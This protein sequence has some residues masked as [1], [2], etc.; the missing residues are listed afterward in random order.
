MNARGATGLNGFW[1]YPTTATEPWRMAER[2][3]IHNGIDA[4]MNGASGAQLKS[5]YQKGQFLDKFSFLVKLRLNPRAQIYA[6]S[7]GPGTP[8]R[9][10]LDKFRLYTIY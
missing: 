8:L 1:S 5:S 7:E 9:G 4:G 6:F 2:D 3:F 10:I